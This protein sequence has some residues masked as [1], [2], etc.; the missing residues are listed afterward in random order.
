MAKKVS[1]NPNDF[2]PIIVNGCLIEP[3]TVYEVTAKEPSDKS[4]DVYTR[5]GSV[6]ER[7][8]GVSNTVSLTQSD[9][10]FF[11]GSPIFNSID[12]VKNNW[13]KRKELADKYFE[14]F[15]L[16]M[17]N[18]ISEIERIRIPTDN[19]FFDRNYPSGYFTVTVGE[20]YQFNTANP[21]DR[22]KLYIAISEGQLSM[23][24]KRTQEE[25][26]EGL[27]DELDM[28]HQDAQY[29]YVSISD[30]KTKKEQRAELEMESS[31]EF[32]N[33]LRSNQD[34]LIGLLSYI[35][36]TVKKDISKA[37]LN[38]LYK[39]KIEEDPTKLKEFIKILKD[40]KTNPKQLT[41]EI[42]L[43]EKLKSKKGREL[44]HK[45]GSSYYMNDTVLGSNLKSVVSTLLKQDNEDLLKQ[46]YLKF[47]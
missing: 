35:N 37:E 36:I 16:P 40:Y 13:V 10:G 46:F 20:G 9:T 32:G 24:G 15:A 1:I 22:F 25:K 33:L 34:V 27:K 18:Y 39:T 14:V 11:E 4:P 29:S 45:D 6:K 38:S 43:L 5:L 26:E 21:V 28:F 2:D 3:N 7:Y 8:P 42:D 41:A 31:Y 19:E 17:R 23:K 30:K 12:N 47:D 44:I